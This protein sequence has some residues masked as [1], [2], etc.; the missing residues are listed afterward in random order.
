MAEWAKA[1]RACVGDLKEI[2]LGENMSNSE[3]QNDSRQPGFLGKLVL[4]FL[5]ALHYRKK[6]PVQ[7]CLE[8]PEVVSDD[9]FPW[10]R[11]LKGML[12]C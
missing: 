10:V 12:D 7:L 9:E 3:W 1:M 4:Y 6:W 11:G 8:L 5:A 2:L